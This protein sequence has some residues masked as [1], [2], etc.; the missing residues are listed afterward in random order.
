[1]SEEGYQKEGNH[2]D[3]AKADDLLMVRPWAERCR[4]VAQI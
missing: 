4:C 2:F 3:T 1:M